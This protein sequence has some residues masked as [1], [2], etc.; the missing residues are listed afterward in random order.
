MS[1]ERPFLTARWSEMLLLNFEVPA[2]A[3]AELAPAG[4]EP[5]LFN[6][7]AYLSIVGFMFRDARYFGLRLPTHREFEEVN[8]RY[9]VPRMVDGRTRHGLESPVVVR[10]AD[11]GVVEVRGE[12]YRGAVLVQ[13]AGRRGLTFVNR[14]DLESYLLGVVPR[15]LG[16]VDSTSVTQRST[17]FSSMKRSEPVPRW[18]IAA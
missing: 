15:E 6:G 10:A 11:G 5:D 12:A 17:T 18:S 7:Q 3:I 2:E 13:N 4:T 14:L 16:D 1:P 8:L 9:Y